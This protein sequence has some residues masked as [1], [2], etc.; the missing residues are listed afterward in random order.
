MAVKPALWVA[1][2]AL[3]GLGGVYGRQAAQLP[4][5]ACAAAGGA[6]GIVQSVYE[7]GEERAQYVVA[8]TP[9]CRLLLTT[10][11]FPEYQVGDRLLL[12][13]EVE[14]LTTMP[15]ELSGYADYLRRRGF[16][17]T[18][19]YPEVQ[20]SQSAKA[21]GDS[22]GT[23]PTL[24]E[25]MHNQ[26]VHIFQEPEASLVLAMVLNE[27]GTI[28]ENV[29][30]QFRRTGVTHIISISGLHVS[31]IAG[32]LVGLALFLPLRPWPRALL[33]LAAIWLYVA[34]IGAPVAALRAAWFWTLAL[35]AFQLR[36]LVSLPTVILLTAV[37]FISVRPLVLQDISFQLSFAGI[38]GIWLALFLFP[39]WRKTW[40]QGLLAS[41]AGATLTT[42]P[43]VAY[44][45]GLVS[46][47]SVASNLLIVPAVTAFLIAAIVGLLLS[48]VVPLAGLAMSF[49]VHLLW[50]WMDIVTAFMSAWDFAAARE[51]AFPLWAVFLSYGLLLAGS[52]GWVRYTRRSWREVW[53]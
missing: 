36:R 20:L 46:F 24:R 49:S 40:W 17:G 11:R 32:T 45:F 39:A 1:A 9:G 50:R 19:R 43:L 21:S 51:V 27:A 52:M 12:T 30:E 25:I 34:F 35:F 13:G 3:F 8:L 6:E 16:G 26:V 2:V 28:P 29:N 5:T 4:V 31:I 38:S 15:S 10:S 47:I 48:F 33:V 18:M 37:G 42:S 41:S 44:H 23:S 7:V 53:E 14:P 22:R